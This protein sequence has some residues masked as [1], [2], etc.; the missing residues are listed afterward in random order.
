MSPNN[1]TLFH[2]CSGGRIAKIAKDRKEDYNMDAPS[3]DFQFK[4]GISGSSS[5]LRW[6]SRVETFHFKG[7]TTWYDLDSVQ[8]TL[9]NTNRQ[10]FVVLKTVYDNHQHSSTTVSLLQN[11]FLCWTRYQTPLP[12]LSPSPW[13]PP[14]CVAEILHV[15]VSI[16]RLNN[17]KALKQKVC[18]DTATSL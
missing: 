2:W 6:N 16:V 4:L 5:D 10:S 3:F 14:V 8:Y 7:F 1:L 9:L 15:S 11:Y 18:V 12:V 13:Q 17:K